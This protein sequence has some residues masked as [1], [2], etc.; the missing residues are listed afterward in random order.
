MS[1]IPDISFLGIG[2]MRTERL[3]TDSTAFSAC[4]VNKKKVNK[5]KM[6]QVET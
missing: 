5:W 1:K 2:Y 4:D 3:K 6:C